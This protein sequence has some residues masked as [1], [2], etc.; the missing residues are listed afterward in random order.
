MQKQRTVT[1]NHNPL[2]K[3]ELPVWRSRFV[4]MVLLGCLLVLV[5]RALF[6]QGI[7][8]EFLQ[9]KGEMRYARVLEVPATRGRITDRNGDMFAVSTPVR[10]IWA[11]PTDVSLE[12]GEA[13]Q[14]ARLLEM[15]VAELN[16]KLASGR[17]FAYLKRQLS[18]DVAE[19]IAALKLTGI[20]EQ[21]EY[22]RFYPGGEVTAHMLGFT[23]VEDRGQEG[24][25]LAYEAQLA[26]QPGSRRVIKDRR[27]QVV[28]DV[29]S[30]RPPRD[31]EDVVLAMDGKIQYLAYSALRDAMQKYRAKAG[32]VVVVDVQTGEVLALANA[33][34]FNPNNRANL[35]G[36]QLR[37]RAFTDTFEPGSVMKPFVAAL[38]LESGKFK[39]TT[40]IDT[41]PGRLTIGSA[42]I[43]DAHVHGILTVAEVIQKSSNVG[44]VKM[45]LQFSPDEMWHL[46]DGLGFG[47]QLN[48]GFPGEATGRLR[49]A[50]SWRPIEQ[51][52]MSYGHGISVS[53]IQLAHA[54]LAF[55]RDGD[56]L[57]LS[58]TRVDTPKAEP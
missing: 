48:L 25:E 35:T 39:A 30:I 44:T 46:L 37:N 42:T 38:A 17:D 49:P 56:L 19:R 26:G 23:S 24:I 52:T 11:I 55:A 22:R 51:A 34:T 41:S 54:Y 3:R 58:L 28:E 9:A 13:R 57:P 14:L 5:G 53:L 33:P 31:G 29:E 43:G 1:F 21:R 32:A 16:A 6:L 27:G 2:L 36:T 18:P 10:S 40:K 12:P 45:A 50:K 4:L 8:N 7:D 47:S 15:D 20:H